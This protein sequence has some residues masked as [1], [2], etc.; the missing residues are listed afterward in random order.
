M[1]LA[2]VVERLVAAELASGERLL[3]VN[4]SRIQG[5]PWD[6]VVF[7]LSPVAD[8]SVPPLLSTLAPFRKGEF[9]LPPWPTSGF[10]APR[11]FITA[12]LP[13]DD[14]RFAQCLSQSPPEAREVV[15]RASDETREPVLFARL[16]RDGSLSDVQNLSREIRRRTWLGFRA[17]PPPL[18]TR[19]IHLSLGAQHARVAPEGGRAIAG[20][21]TG[22]AQVTVFPA[23]A[24]SPN[25]TCRTLSGDGR[26]RTLTVSARA[27]ADAL[28]LPLNSY[29]G[30]PIEFPIELEIVSE[31]AYEN[32]EDVIG[33]LSSGAAGLR[34]ARE[35][36][37]R[38]I[39][40]RVEGTIRRLDLR[41]RRMQSRDSIRVREPGGASKII[42]VVPTN[43]HE[44]LILTG[45]LETYIEQVLP[46]FHILEHTS[47]AGIDALANVQLSKDANVATGATLEFEYAL[48]N[49]FRHSHPIR[50]TE[51]I[52]CWCLGGIE[53]GTH[54]YGDGAIDRDGELEFRMSGESWLRVLD[55]GDH[56]IDALVLE[57]LPALR[58]AR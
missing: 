10:F 23:V 14:D 58:T 7:S 18:R 39:E 53:N 54:R 46:V 19:H 37:L 55:F 40:D 11:D 22:R 25:V 8:C 29:Y 26:V 5:A 28:G 2:T 32:G 21:D 1:R 15:T 34:R 57:R 9:L 51:F 16:Q 3:R 42:G 13:C 47:Q 27:V 44:V 6:W 33:A 17:L 30:F 35:Y 20:T 4:V 50:Q 49:F 36:C 31:V 38:T 24:A 12:E 41:R 56:L 52:V 43:E 48:E 45:K